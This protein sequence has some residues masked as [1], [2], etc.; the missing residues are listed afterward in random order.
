MVLVLLISF[1]LAGRAGF[2][3]DAG[4]FWPSVAGELVVATN[5]N[6]F[7]TDQ[8]FDTNIFDF[9]TNYFQAYDVPLATNDN[10]ST[11]RMTDRAG[12]TTT[13]NFDVI[14]NY[15]GATNAPLVTLIWPQ[16]G[17]A[18]SSS[19]CTIRGTMSD[20]TGTLLA[21]IVSNDGTNIVTNTVSGLI[22]RNNMFWLE[23]VPLNGTNQISIQAVDASGKNVAVTNFTVY[24][25]HLILTINSTPTG[26]DLY[27]PFG[28]V[29]GTVSDPSVTVIVNGTNATVRPDVND[30]GTYNWNADSVRIRG[31]G[32][33]TFD[34]A[35]YAMGV[36]GGGT[37]SRT[38]KRWPQ[39]TWK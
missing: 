15:A 10:V 14:L 35:A 33:A 23:N 13:T 3:W 22:E 19:S 8:L 26:D 2:S 32:T 25:R 24:P 34:A 6:V 4:W 30:T 11:L 28:P 16:D 12:N 5:L 17:L 9:T 27:Q 7:V 20:E 39:L 18:V 37:P 38:P 29:S 36:G 1:A 21:Q 31:L